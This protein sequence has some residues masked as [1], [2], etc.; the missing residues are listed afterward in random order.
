MKTC[1]REALEA[2]VADELAPA[3]AAEVTAHAETCEACARLAAACR[4]TSAE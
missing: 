1:D 2:L 3:R 4:T